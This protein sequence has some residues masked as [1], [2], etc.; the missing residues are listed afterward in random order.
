[1]QNFFGVGDSSNT[2]GD[3]ERNV[4]SR[5]DI[6]YPVS[7]DGAAI[8]ARGYVVEHEFIGAVATIFFREFEHISDDA[9]IAELHALDDLAVTNVEAGYY[10]A[11]RNVSISLAVILP[12]RRA[13]PL[14]VARAP[15]VL[16]A[17]RSSIL[18]TPPDACSRM[19]GY[20][21]ITCA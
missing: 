14:M 18:R 8:R 12:S 17:C 19:S 2:T 16:S 3:T 13:R 4:E 1:M 5:G 11:G 9:M 21:S 6:T 15:V 10:A 7:V 20:R